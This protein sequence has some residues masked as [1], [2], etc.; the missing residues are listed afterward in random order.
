MRLGRLSIVGLAFAAVAGGARAR[1]ATTEGLQRDDRE[2]EPPAVTANQ[3]AMAAGA[4][5]PLALSPTVGDVAAVGAGFGGYDAARGSAVMQSF[6]EVRLWGR[7]ALRGAAERGDSSDRLRPAV[8]A[9]LQL[10][11]QQRHAVDGA[12]SVSYRA[13]GLTEPEGEIET[14]VSLGRRVGRTSLIAN[15]AYGQDP[16]GRERDGE[17][18]AAALARLSDRFYAGIDGRWRFDLGSHPAKLRASKEATFDLDAGPVAMAT[19]GPLALAVHG[20]ASV[21][22][23][24]GR[25]ASVGLVALAGVGTSF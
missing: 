11:T 8:A 10:L 17:V 2:V 16:E 13:E 14:V 12:V 9:R 22:R 6:V 5:L 19:L 25:D 1:A 4:Y 15:L 20:G 24:A 23:L 3:R 7:L 21:V 18:R